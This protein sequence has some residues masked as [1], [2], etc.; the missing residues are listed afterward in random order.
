MSEPT[1][2]GEPAP[3]DLTDAPGVSEEERAESAWLIAR[4]KDP[5]ALPPNARIANA[6]AEIETLLGSLPAPAEDDG[7]QTE[8]LDLAMRQRRRRRGIQRVAWVAATAT[9]VVCIL[10]LV[11]QPRSELIALTKEAPEL[12]LAL[13]PGKSRR[14]EGPTA[15]VGDHLIVKALSDGRAELRVYHNEQ[16]LLAR[17]PAGPGCVSVT[18]Q[19]LAIDVELKAPGTYQIILILGLDD[20]VSTDQTSAYGAYVD[21]AMAAK[22]RIVMHSPLKVL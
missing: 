11:S 7:W 16:T 21:A 5:N 13:R 18:K 15:S 2:N 14:A 9:V 22:A 10:L 17:C 20:S 19:E 8:V 3:S 1:P 12:D 4:D 6:Y